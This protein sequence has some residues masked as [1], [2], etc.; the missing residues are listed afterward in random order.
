M[1]MIR[2]TSLISLGLAVMTAVMPAAGALAKE[3]AAPKT[4]T[5]I[6]NIIVVIAEN[7]SYDHVFATYVPANHERAANLL[8][9]GI[10]NADGSPGPNFALGAQFTVP[11]QASF[12][13][14][15]PSKT[16]YVFLPPP[17]TLGAHTAGSDTAPPPFATV[18]AASAEL[19]LE[20]ADLP[21]L[22]RGATG[23]PLRSVDA[24]VTN[25][26]SL[27]NGPF[28]LTGSTMPYDA[29]TGDTIHRFYQMWQQS[30]CSLSNATP[31]N[32]TGC[33]SDA[34]RS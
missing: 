28:Q 26:T 31:E 27:P 12:Y 6:R 30:D 29:Y 11:P 22:T 24:R 17:D 34:T 14:G 32:P 25:A 23:L 9:K 7:R 4:S 3:D 19:D 10:V 13:I 33:L 21:L 8:S 20:P 18:G 1:Q 5:P 2:G 15:A 16:P